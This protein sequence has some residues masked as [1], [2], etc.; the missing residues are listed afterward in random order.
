M[1]VRPVIEAFE[2]SSDA[3]EPTCGGNPTHPCTAA[4][5]GQD[6]IVL[7]GADDG[8]T[9]R[10]GTVVVASDDIAS[11]KAITVSVNSQPTW[12]I[13]IVLTTSGKARFAEATTAMVGK[14]MAIVVDGVVQSAPTVQTPI[15]EGTVEI[16][17]DFTQEDAERLASSISP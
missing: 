9:Y 14:Q 10:L 2:P 8:V 7:R 5:L 15:T 4:A 13:E 3:P 12:A 6:E 17:G 16:T 1:Q 11:A